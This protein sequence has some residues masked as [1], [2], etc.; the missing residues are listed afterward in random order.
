[1]DKLQ[2]HGQQTGIQKAFVKTTHRVLLVSRGTVRASRLP[3]LLKYSALPSLMMP[4]PP[5]ICPPLRLCQSGLSFPSN[6][7]V[8]SVGLATD[9][10]QLSCSTV[11]KKL[12]RIKQDKI[13]PFGLQ[14]IFQVH[15]LCIPCHRST[16]QRCNL[17]VPHSGLDRALRCRPHPKQKVE[18]LYKDCSLGTSGIWFYWK[19]ER[20]KVG[21]GRNGADI[22]SM[23]CVI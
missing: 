22:S 18:H 2:I 17:H 16:R 5:P 10:T 20:D 1:M 6:P 14:T 21:L 4:Q 7:S 8:S 13:Q 12:K 19:L 11:G 23:S 3:G 15:Y 9:G